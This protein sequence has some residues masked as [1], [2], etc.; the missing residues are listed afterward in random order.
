MCA[1]IKSKQEAAAVSEDTPK[2][3]QD[4]Q[5][6]AG[7]LHYPVNTCTLIKTSNKILYCE[8]TVELLCDSTALT[9]PV[10]FEA[11]GEEEE[12]KSQKDATRQHGPNH[13]T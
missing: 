13:S 6:G 7:H 10:V 5:V 1:F 2:E 11:Q 12:A 8:F 4:I 9:V 3:S